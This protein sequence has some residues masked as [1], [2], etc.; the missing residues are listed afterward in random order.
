MWHAR[1]RC[2]DYTILGQ[3]VGDCHSLLNV[4]AISGTHGPA[5]RGGAFNLS[6]HRTAGSDCELSVHFSANWQI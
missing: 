1:D 3:D 5:G 2:R 6:P 4:M